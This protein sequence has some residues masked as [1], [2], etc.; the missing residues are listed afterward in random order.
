MNIHGKSRGNPEKGNPRNLDDPRNRNS[1]Y[2]PTHE[3]F[4]FFNTTLFFY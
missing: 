2:V 3:F 1:M 4:R